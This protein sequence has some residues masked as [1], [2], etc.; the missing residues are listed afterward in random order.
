MSQQNSPVEQ[1]VLGRT[2]S[3]AWKTFTSAWGLLVVAGLALI[4]ASI[5]GGV[6]GQVVGMIQH[7]MLEN[8]A[9]PARIVVL[10][11]IVAPVL[12]LL[13]ACLQ[14]PMQIGVGLTAVRASRG[15]RQCF[16]TIF[17]GFRRFGSAVGAMLLMAVLGIAAVVPG[18]VI[19][20]VGMFGAINSG[21]SPRPI[22]IL[23]IIVGALI[24]VCVSL[25]LT[26]RLMVFPLRA[27]DPDLP[28]VGVFEALRLSW[29]ATRGHALAGIVTMLLSTVAIVLGFGCCCIGLVLFGFPL[30]IALQAG[31]YRAVFNDA[32]PN[33]PPPPP[34]WTGDVPPQMPA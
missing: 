21:G 29:S 34:P 24:A 13:S 14:W 18:M 9:P 31:Y 3:L 28:R 26:A 5:P 25:W 4:A 33:T 20:A 19:A 15:D 7:A 17:E 12:I 10:W 32:D 1:D 16:A 30:W 27:C 8:G 22:A 2:L 6:L 23:L 11:V